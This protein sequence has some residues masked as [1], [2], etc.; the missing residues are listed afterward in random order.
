MKT[1]NYNFIYNVNFYFQKVEQSINDLHFDQ[2]E[3]FFF[4]YLRGNWN[5]R[6]TSFVFRFGHTFM[7]ENGRG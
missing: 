5:G 7:G 3:H 1:S 2:R 4:F 6:I